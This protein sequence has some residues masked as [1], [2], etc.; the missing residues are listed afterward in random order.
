MDVYSRHKELINLYYLN[1]PGATSRLQR[2][3]SK[4]RTDYDVIQSNHK[5][6]WDEDEVDFFPWH[7]ISF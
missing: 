7:L 6:L 3:T 1:H 2:N 4:D 5:F